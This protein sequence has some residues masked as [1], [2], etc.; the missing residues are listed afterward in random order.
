MPSFYTHS[1]H[2]AIARISSG[3]AKLKTVDLSSRKKRGG[4]GGSQIVVGLPATAP[5]RHRGTVSGLQSLDR[6]DRCQNRALSGHQHQNQIDG[7]DLQQIHQRHVSSHRQGAACQSLA[8][9]VDPWLPPNQE[10]THSSLLYATTPPHRPARSTWRIYLCGEYTSIFGYLSLV[11]AR[12]GAPSMLGAASQL[13]TQQINIQNT[14]NFFFF[15]RIKKKKKQTIMATERCRL[16]RQL[17]NQM[18]ALIDT[19]MARHDY[20]ELTDKRLTDIQLRRVV[21]DLTA[22]TW[23]WAGRNLL[24]DVS[25]LLA[26]GRPANLQDSLLELGSQSPKRGNVLGYGGSTAHLHDTDRAVSQ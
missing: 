3:D 20:V 17:S 11:A 12:L 13:R 1:A 26:G 6:R 8:G 22:V 16:L 19:M 15:F 25:G 7:L 2:K 23:L 9:A 18:A 14:R 4:G 21:P 24:T 10:S 5:R